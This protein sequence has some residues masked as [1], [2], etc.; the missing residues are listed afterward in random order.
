MKS[1]GVY[2]GHPEILRY[3]QNDIKAQI[4]TIVRTDQIITIIKI[5]HN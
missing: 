1:P 5:Y 4:I 3:V 2:H